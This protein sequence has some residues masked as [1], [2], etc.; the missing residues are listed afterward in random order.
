MTTVSELSTMAAKSPAELLQLCMTR[1]R[2]GRPPMP[3]LDRLTAARCRALLYAN[4]T[5]DIAADMDAKDQRALLVVADAFLRVHDELAGLRWF[6]WPSTVREA[7]RDT[8]YFLD[9]AATR[10]LLKQMGLSL[11]RGRRE[12]A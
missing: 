9:G 4:T 8:L 7:R 11:P 1:A 12:A 3:G 5:I 6:S 2:R 10:R